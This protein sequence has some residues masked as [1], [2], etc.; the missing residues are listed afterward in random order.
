MGSI[1]QFNEPS[2]AHI[3]STAPTRRVL[4]PR[5]QTQRI[6]EAT[7]TNFE[8]LI[9]GRQES[10]P[11]S[12]F[13]TGRRI[14]DFTYFLETLKNLNKHNEFNCNLNDIFVEKEEVN[15]LCTSYVVK[16]AVCNFE[17]VIT[18]EPPTEQL[19]NHQLVLIMMKLKCSYK[20]MKKLLT[21]MGLPVITHADFI[22]ERDKISVLKKN[23]QTDKKI[24]KCTYNLVNE[25]LISMGY[26]AI[27]HADFIRERDTI[28]LFNKNHKT[29]NKIP[30][31]SYKFMKKLLTLMDLPTVTRADFIRKRNKISLLNKNK[32]TSKISP[33]VSPKT[34]SKFDK[35]PEQECN[36]SDS[37]N[38]LFEEVDLS[39]LL[40]HDQFKIKKKNPPKNESNSVLPLPTSSAFDDKLIF[41]QKQRTLTTTI[42]KRESNSSMN[43]GELTSSRTS[44][45]QTQNK[46][47]APENDKQSKVVSY[48]P[49][50]IITDE[51]TNQ[52]QTTS[53]EIII[54]QEI[55]S[56]LDNEEL[57]NS[58]ISELQMS[59]KESL[60]EKDEQC[61]ALLSHLFAEKVEAC[62]NRMVFSQK[63]ADLHKNVAIKKIHQVTEDNFRLVKSKFNSIGMIDK[64][65]INEFPNHSDLE[66]FH[67]KAAYKDR[68]IVNE[69]HN[70]EVKRKLL[71]VD[72]YERIN[73][74]RISFHSDKKAEN[75]SR[76]SLH[77]D[78]LDNP[79]SR[80]DA[81]N[82]SKA[83]VFSLFLLF[84]C[85]YY[86]YYY[87]D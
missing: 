17:S 84:T 18:S 29:D 73:N 61:N 43:D 62:K 46:E 33:K 19:N 65:G 76:K 70:K 45:K 13:I 39:N 16:C 68:M 15:G 21:A 72:N 24:P 8:E 27:T 22:R 71:L 69:E 3:V 81:A 12:T 10:L 66:L 47:N 38:S 57:T 6:N 9:E 53:D 28:S 49:K 34:I 83:I 78:E 36:S 4:R 48:Q 85:Y 31:C 64:E 5:P 58:K 30:K 2:I 86:Y 79:V 59:T 87:F 54:K 52:E 60:I 75:E 77:T 40:M 42:T 56:P 26:P 32:K 51:N 55:N 37:N 67:R 63:H 35:I 25:L 14:I 50:E 44:G 20:F 23:Q 80:Y 41:N 11:K 1:A 74:K 82:Q 7:Q